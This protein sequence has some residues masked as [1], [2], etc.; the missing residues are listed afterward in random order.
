[1]ALSYETL[2][3]APRSQEV[4][5]FKMSQVNR[6]QSEQP[7][8]A[9]AQNE[10]NAQKLNRPGKAEEKSET[11]FKFDAKDKGS[12]EYQRKEQERK[13]KE[14]QIRNEEH[15]KMYGCTFDITI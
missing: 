14:E 9:L 2:V 5:N 10:Q 3:V 8:I 12:N 7:T 13:K 11:P 1:M 15:R 4:T 6:Q